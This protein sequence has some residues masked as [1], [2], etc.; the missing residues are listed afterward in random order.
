MQYYRSL[1]EAVLEAGQM[2]HLV[3]ELDGVVLEMELAAGPAAAER[4]VKRPIDRLTDEVADK[5]D[6]RL[7]D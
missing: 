2:S 6:L 1:V 3:N 5:V 4:Q 7:D